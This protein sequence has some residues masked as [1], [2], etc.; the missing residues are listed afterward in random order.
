MAIAVSVNSLGA[1][2]ADMRIWLI[3]DPTQGELDYSVPF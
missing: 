1:S 2:R 3:F